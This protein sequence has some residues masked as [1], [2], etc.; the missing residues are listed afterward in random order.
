MDRAHFWSLIHAAIRQYRDDVWQ[1]AAAIEDALA[2]LDAP[3]I[4]SFHQHF[5]ELMDESYGADLWSVISFI[6]GGCGNDGFDYFRGW[7]IAQGEEVFRMV[8]ARPGWLGPYVQWQDCAACCEAMLNVSYNAYQRRTGS[9][10]FREDR[11]AVHRD[12]KGALLCEDELRRRFPEV[13]Y[14]VAQGIGPGMNIDIDE[15]PP[16]KYTLMLDGADQQT[17]ALF[18][19][20]GLQGGG[21]TWLQIV[22][23]LVEM[24]LPAALPGLDFNAEADNLCVSS[25]NRQLLEQVFALVW[26]AVADHQLLQAAMDHAGDELV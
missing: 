24:R 22:F 23:S 25:S 13:W 17:Y 11:A 9:R 6:D 4:E 2:D 14:P 1:R 18:D 26:E 19:A 10:D 5:W 20:R 3:E 8:M 12:L 7:L 16:G 21:H 15:Y